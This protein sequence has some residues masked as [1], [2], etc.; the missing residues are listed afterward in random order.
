MEN[1]KIM[2]KETIQAYYNS[3]VWINKKIDEFIY[4]NMRI[5]KCIELLDEFLDAQKC[6]SICDI[7]CSIGLTSYEMHV[8][9][10]DIKIDGFDIACDQ[11]EFAKKVFSN[12]NLNFYCHDFA[13]TPEGKKY[14]IITLFDVFEHIP[15]ARRNDFVS[16]IKELLDENSIILI[17]TPSYIKSRYDI[18]NRP[19]LLQVVDEVIT[20]KELYEFAEIVGGSLVYYKLE[21]VWE[22][23]DYSHCVISKV[24]GLKRKEIK[25]QPSILDKIKNKLGL[26]ER[27]RRI[28]ERKKIIEDHLLVH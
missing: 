17:T 18:E 12:E 13:S 24:K 2:N 8:K 22:K 21:T 15:P 25:Y 11:I 28:K 1:N 6:Y 9:Y 7:G 10:P 26:S 5:S 23:Y 14:D 3:N 4:G 19:E 20:P 27:Q 16:S